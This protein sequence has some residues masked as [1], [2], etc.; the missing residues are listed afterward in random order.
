MLI[1]KVNRKFQIGFAP[2]LVRRLVCFG[3][4]SSMDAQSSYGSDGEELVHL[5]REMQQGHAPKHTIAIP[6]G[7]HVRRKVYL[8]RP[9]PPRSGQGLLPWLT[10]VLHAS[11]QP[12]IEAV[13]TVDTT[14]RRNDP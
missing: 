3:R 10:M 4:C 7:N 14:E 13:R 9:T 12:P 2:F 11:K 1:E 5:I 8:M 6:V